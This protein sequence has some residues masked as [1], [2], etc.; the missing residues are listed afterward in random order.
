[1]CDM[2]VIQIID[3]LNVGGAERVLIGLCNILQS[4]GVKVSVCVL[5]DKLNLL[6]YLDKQIP[7]YRLRREFKWSL[8][9]LYE[10]NRLCSSFDIVHV[11]LRYNLRYVG[12]AKLLFGGKYRIVLHDHFGDIEKDRTVPRGLSFFMTRAWYIGVHPALLEWAVNDVKIKREQVFFLAN[13]IQK[14]TSANMPDLK[15]AVERS[16]FSLIKVANFR[17]SK[18][19]VFAVRLL[20]QLSKQQVVKL[21]LI[22]GINESEYY[23]EVRASVMQMSLNNQVEFIHDIKDVQPELYKYT[24]AIHTASMESG[25]LVLLEYLAVGLPFL[26][27]K[28]GQVAEELQPDF[29]EFFLETFKIQDWIDRIQ[30]ILKMNLPA[31]Q[32]RMIK[33]FERQYAPEVYGERCQALYRQIMES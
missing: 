19:Q 1:M 28:T 31:L 23:K 2:R 22:G 6:P 33:H 26:A 30:L 7:V 17:P 21:A 8:F 24:L 5:T 25:P 29:P 9:K 10:I 32:Q 18:N 16:E 12:L 27:Y 20:E 15:D 13:T 11:H 4:Q 3:S 14:S